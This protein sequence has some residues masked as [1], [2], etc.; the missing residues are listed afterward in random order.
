MS[1]IKKFSIS[2]ITK[3]IDK[4][5]SLLVRS[6]GVC[7]ACEVS[8]CGGPLQD[9]H[10]IGRANRTLRWDIMNHLCL[11]Y[12]HHIFFAH[13]DPVEFLLWFQKKYPERWEYLLE[14]RKR[15]IKRIPDDYR[16]LLE[17]VRNRNISKL[18]VSIDFV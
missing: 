13:H 7:A 2:R 1:K 4:E 9:A 15:L 6:S 3:Q 11:C 8:G 18:H 14:T 5:F 17:N 16:E 10:I 12:R